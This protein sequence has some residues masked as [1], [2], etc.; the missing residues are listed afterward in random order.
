MK[1]I[2]KF[3]VFAKVSLT[4]DLAYRATILIRFLFYAFFIYVL[5][6]LWRTV[7]Q[8]NSING[9]SY[10]QI[11]WYLITTELIT[12]VVGSDFFRIMNEDIKSG[13]IAYQLGRPVHYVFYQFATTI[14]QSLAV[15]VCFGFLA[16]CLGFLLAGPLP[17]FSPGGMPAFALSFALSIVLQFFILMLIGLS[18]FV[19]EDNFGVYLIYQKACFMLGMLLPVEFLP[20]W[21]QS[22]AKALPFSYVCWAPASILVN[23]SPEAAFALISRQAAWA[24]FAVVAVLTSYRAAVRSLQVNG[25]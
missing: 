18:S 20:A 21:L 12:T 8:G 24:A 7:Y 5:M 19:L 17:T 9:Y 1:A 23:Y 16:I 2:R 22:I 10:S 4:N 15:L 6:S 3:Y 13:A 14:G 11:M 25:G